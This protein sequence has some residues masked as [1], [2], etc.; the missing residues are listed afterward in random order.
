MGAVYQKLGETME[1]LWDKSLRL[2]TVHIDDV[3]SALFLITTKAQNKEIFNLVD[4]SD[5]DQGSMNKFVSQ[6]FG[7]KTD[8]MGTIKSGIATTV[9]MKTVADVANDKHLQP[10]S[11]LLKEHKLNDS[12]LTPYLDEEVLY[13]NSTSLDGT[14]ITKVLNFQ[15]SHP[16]ITVESLK[17]VIVDFE[18]RGTFPKGLLKI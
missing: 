5:T 6:L 9:S 13:N 8:F 3:V 18:N 2:C 11:E 14:K 12:P 4:S 17:E 1:L 16:Q 10:W 7:I 15:Y